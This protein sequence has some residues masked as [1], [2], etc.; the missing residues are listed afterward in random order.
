M[1]KKNIL[2]LNEC[3]IASAKQIFV[4]ELIPVKTNGDKMKSLCFFTKNEQYTLFITR[5]CFMFTP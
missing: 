2:F 1:K 3:Q 5:Y 4:P